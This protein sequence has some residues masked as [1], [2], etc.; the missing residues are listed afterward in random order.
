M[1]LKIC[2]VT[3]YVVKG[4]GQGRANYEVVLEAIRRGHQITLLANQVDPQLQHSSQVSWIPI[5]FGALPTQLL[6][7]LEFAWQSASWLRQ[8]RHE[9]DVVQVYGAITAV[10]GDI[11]TVQFVHSAW[12]RS[13][14]HISR[15]RR[16]A[17]GFYQWLYTACNAWWEKPAFLQAKVVVAVSE[18]IKQELVDIGVPQERI[19]VILNGVD[20]DEF[21]PTDANRKTLGLPENVTLGVFV[22]DIRTPRKNL[23]TV[24]Q[25]LSQVPDLHLAVVGSTAGSPFPQLAASL[26]ISER[27]HFLGYRR[28]IAQ[29]MQASDL[30]VFP[31]R[32]EAC[33][34]V[35]LEAMASGL[36]VITAA[37]AGGAEI[38]TPEC[39]VVLADSEDIQ[40]LVAALSTLKTDP[41]RS[42]HMGQVARAI[43]QQH[44]WVSKA[45]S[46]VDL[47][48][49]LSATKA[50]SHKQFVSQTG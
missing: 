6:R 3:P 36:P 31:S 21:A 45:E 13:P 8:H 5:T 24:L 32:Y 26:N 10:A 41:E 38:V 39:G 47:F 14:V 29:I 27:V 4:D 19:Q 33:T 9:F 37:T 15:I 1:A 17:Y 22:G 30:F 12:L 46:Y 28:D 20:L 42:H 43:A 49:K 50:V 18:K 25:A 34:L 44:S 23:D 16:D 40:T 2:I 11:N 35:L 48:E 7:N